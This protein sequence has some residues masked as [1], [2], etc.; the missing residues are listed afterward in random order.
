MQ[1]TGEFDALL[2]DVL[3]V[4]NCVAERKLKINEKEIFESKELGIT[5][6]V[7]EEQ[8]KLFEK[9]QKFLES[10]VYVDLYDLLNFYK[11]QC[12]SLDEEVKCL[13]DKSFI[14]FD[15]PVN[16]VE[17]SCFYLWIIINLVYIV[18]LFPFKLSLIK[19]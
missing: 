19:I 3:T 15:Y 6:S 5:D 1:A 4:M 7:D 14:I 18:N 11:D 16:V 2:S 17:V 8:K 12:S 10:S 13:N 9:Y